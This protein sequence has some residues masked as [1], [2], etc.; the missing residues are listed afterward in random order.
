ML[1]L[2]GIAGADGSAAVAVATGA[3]AEGSE[4]MP[5]DC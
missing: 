1:G 3:P 5:A 4:D 2:C